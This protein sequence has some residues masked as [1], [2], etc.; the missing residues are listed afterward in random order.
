MESSL[1][2]KRIVLGVTGGIAA[3]KVPYLIRLLKK[4]GAEVKCIMTPSAS[5]FVTAGTLSTLSENIV[6]CDFWE[7]GNSTWNN[8]VELGLWADLMLVAPLTANTLAKMTHGIC[9][10]ILL[11]TYLS[12]KCS[13]MLAP[14]MDLDMYAHP[15]TKENI[16]KLIQRGNIV[17]PANSGA[18]AS[19]LN[20]EGRMQEPEE[21]FNHVQSFFNSAQSFSGTKILIT[22]GPTF[23]P[24][25][26]VRFIGNHSSGKMGYALASDFLK[27]GAEVVLITGP[28]DQSLVHENLKIVPVLTALE[29]LEAVQVYWS[30]MNG[31]IFAAAVA[32][33]K[34][35]HVASEKIKKHSDHLNLELV[36]NPDILAWAGAHKK[37]KQWLGGFALETENLLENAR[38]KLTKKNLDFIV[39]NCMNDE[40]AGFGVDTNQV[41]ILAKNNISLNLE[42]AS[43]ASIARSIVEF[44]EDKVK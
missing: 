15:T 38:A 33:Y 4:S 34:P 29:M 19:G 2:G 43:K 8:H 28:N 6:I 13:V 14:A 27:K 42:L 32:D 12:A 37:Q 23:E 30:G 26:P 10:N 16:S 21:I 22:A 7:S 17:L 31:G 20:G 24:I 3:F 39:A 18:L 36:K 11:A 9:D 25:D 35:K 5:A 41:T 44:V 1:K 40:G